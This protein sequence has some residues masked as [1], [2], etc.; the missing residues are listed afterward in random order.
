MVKRCYPRRNMDPKD[1][2]KSDRTL[3]VRTYQAV[4]DGRWWTLAALSKRLKSDTPGISA[5]LRSLRHPRYGGY[6][7]AVR[8]LHGD[9]GG[10]RVYEYRLFPPGTVVPMRN[11][12]GKPSNDFAR[13]LQ[14]EIRLRNNMLADVYQL[15]RDVHLTTCAWSKKAGTDIRGVIHYCE[16]PP[17]SICQKAKAA[18]SILYEAMR[19]TLNT[20]RKADIHVGTHR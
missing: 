1:A 18:A 12:V 9:G 4:R 11:R 17:D 13:D 8:F 6:S 3:L 5:T 7:V 19:L 10:K 15:I 14:K 20:P 16:C 2:P